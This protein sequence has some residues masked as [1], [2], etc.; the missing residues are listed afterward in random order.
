M[1]ITLIRI[2]ERLIHGQTAYSWATAYPT[3]QFMVV[4]DELA[5]DSFQKD[6]LEMAVPQDKSFQLLN[7]VGAIKYLS[8]TIYPSTMI[9]VKSPMT[10]LSLA[11]AGIPIT[12]V[13]IGGMY[14]RSDRKEFNKTVYLNDD[15]I[16]TFKK[17]AN[18]GIRL[19]LRTT[20]EDH[21][22]NLAEKLQRRE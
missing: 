9:I 4:D 5:K 16:T 1:A 8:K 18:K 12:F 2:D 14:F 19:D 7:V 22:I 6:L 21:S 11:E 17:L 10:V 3:D 13:N 15:E 20:P